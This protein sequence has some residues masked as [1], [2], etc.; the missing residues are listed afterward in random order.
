MMFL[1]PNISGRMML[2]ALLPY[3]LSILAI[4]AMIA[5]YV[6]FTQNLRNGVLERERN[7]ALGSALVLESVLRDDDLALRFFETQVR[8]GQPHLRMKTD[9][10]DVL[11]IGEFDLAFASEG[12]ELPFSEDSI[13]YV[14]ISTM[15]PVVST[16]DIGKES[17]ILLYYPMADLQGRDALARILF[18]SS[19]GDGTIVHSR[20]GIYLLGSALILLLLMPGVFL[21]LAEMRRRIEKAGFYD[22]DSSLGRENADDPMISDTCPPKMMDEKEFPALFRL[23]SDGRVLYMNLSAEKAL[24]IGRDDARG[25]LFS[26]LPCFAPEERERIVL[27]DEGTSRLELSLINSSGGSVRAGLLMEKL[28]DSG[29]AVSVGRIQGSDKSEESRETSMR[30]RDSA[31]AGADTDLIMD[32]SSMLLDARKRFRNQEEVIEYLGRIQDLLKSASRN[33]MTPEVSGPATVE[34]FSE[35]DAI[36]TALNDVLPDRASIQLDAPGFLPEVECSRE[37]FTQIVKNMVFFSLES[38]TGPVRI[39]L[40]A[41]DVPSPV[42]DSVFSTNCDRTVPRSVSLSYTDGTRIPVVLKEALMD[43][44]TDLTGI[45]RD[46]GSHVSSVA[47]VLSR[48]DCHPVFTEGTTG[49]TLNILFRISEGYLF[50]QTPGEVRPRMDLSLISLAICD[51]SKALRESVSE[52]LGLLGISV[53][54]Y[55]DLDAAKDILE[56]CSYLILDMSVLLDPLDEVLDLLKNDFPGLR[57]IVTSS[58]AEEELELPES[59]ERVVRYLEKP[60]AIDDI[61]NT[62]EL[63]DAASG[64]HDNPAVADER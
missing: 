51:G 1:F 5:G 61:L 58:L 50:D 8:D 25:F 42:S 35:L 44:E 16:V 59:T 53:S 10:Q 62:V 27:P 64:M 33:G 3:I 24:D 49:S 56:G 28:S 17:N 38:N 45:Q 60:Y 57:I 23:D 37:D 22:G 48:L 7:R 39:R 18:S 2:K 63:T 43:P 36:S 4:I 55:D 54:T 11:G 14:S 20:Y 32:I 46:F 26:E 19:I 21:R 13:A 52:A 34:M 41:R 9:L 15:D 40:G 12:S 47:S 29:Y 31:V 30:V 6:Q